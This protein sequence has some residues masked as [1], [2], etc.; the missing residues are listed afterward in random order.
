MSVPSDEIRREL[1]PLE[2]VLWSGRPRQGVFLRL[3]DAVQIPFSLF[4]CGF[5]AF[6]EHGVVQSGSI[7]MMLWG[8]PFILVGLH[9]LVGRFLLDA[10]QRACT[11][12][13]VT[14]QRVL[15]VNYLFTRR[16]RSVELAGLSEMTLTERRDGRGSITFGRPIGGRG[17]SLGGDSG[18]SPGSPNATPRFDLIEGAS[19]VQQTIRQAAARVSR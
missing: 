19:G 10:W 16:V 12:Y 14:D 13:A 9:L 7:F 17:R 2:Q 5:I 8:I 3:S 18:W 4:W 11:D 1:A 6:W 15:I